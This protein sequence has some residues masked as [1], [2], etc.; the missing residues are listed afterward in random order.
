VIHLQIVTLT[1]TKFDDE[2]YEVVLPTLDGEIGVLPGH[3]PLVSVATAGVISIRRK[4]KDPD[5]SREFFATNGGVIEVS[6]NVLR[7]IVDEAD[8][9]N[10]IDEAEAE[11]AHQRAVR[12][13]AEA[14]D[15]LSLEH[16]QSLIDRSAIRL[17]VAGLK[18]RHQKL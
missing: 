2:A 16:A 15:E 11:A 14:K 7:V 12:M 13:K 3:M 4:A 1:G 18:R 17:Q 5:W 8:H 9:A 6:D 10:E